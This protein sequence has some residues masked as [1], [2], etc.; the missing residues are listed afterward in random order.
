MNNNNELDPNSPYYNDNLAILNSPEHKAKIEEQKRKI[1]EFKAIQNQSIEQPQNSNIQ[2][3]LSEETLPSVS[4]TL[5]PSPTS[6]VEDPRLTEALDQQRKYNLYSNLLKGFQ[7]IASAKA[8]GYGYKPEYHGSE[9]LKE[10]ANAPIE[11]YKA[12]LA[13]EKAKKEE[14]REEEAHAIKLD[15]FQVKLKRAKLDLTNDELNNDPTSLNSKFAQERLIDVREKQLKRTLTDEEKANISKQ[16][17]VTIY[18]YLP[19]LQKDIYNVLSYEQKEREINAR[20]EEIKTRNKEENAKQ[21]MYDEDR[22]ANRKLREDTAK[23]NQLLRKDAKLDREVESI[24]K[25][26]EKEMLPQREAAMGE[27]ESFIL[28]QGVLLDDPN[29]YKKANIPGMGVGGGWRPDFATPQEAVDFRQ[30]VQSLA[31]QLLK[32]RSGAAVTDQEYARFLKEVGSGNFSSEANLMT[33]LRKM[34]RDIHLQKNN[35][36][37]SADPEARNEYLKRMGEE[38]QS[39]SNTVKMRDPK[40][41]IRIVPKEEVEAAIKAGGQVVE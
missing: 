31:N 26:F 7:Q 17:A 28:K 5:P 33:G 1:A 9:I 20:M 27:L 4:K 39:V 24:S 16:N 40:G 15:D 22:D 35:I 34:K 29:S 38:I 3:T 19:E 25:R 18:Q 13:L 36:L 11:K 41:N 32:V 23:E 14:K 8:I 2:S 12:Q 6:E 30:N 21:R 37:K 10:M